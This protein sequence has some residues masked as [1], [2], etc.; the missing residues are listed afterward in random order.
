MQDISYVKNITIIGT[1]IQGHAIAQV[2]LMAGFSKVILNDLSIELINKAVDRIV[3]DP[4]TGL[5]VLEKEGQLEN[6]ITTEILVKRLVKEVNLQNAVENVDF[7]IEA[8]PEVMNIKKE[9]FRKLGQYCPEHT[10]F[11]TNTSTMSITEIGKASG[12]SEK[13]IGMHFF[14][15]LEN[16]LIEITKGEKT[17]EDTLKI[18]TEVGHK[19]PSLE[20]KRLLIE[21]QR[22]SPGFI[23]N[24]IVGTIEIYITWLIEQAIARNIPFE[25][26]DADV[27]DFMPMGIFCLCDYIGIDTVFNAMKYFEE[28]LSPDFA[29]HKLFTKL[30]NENNLGQ[31]TG[32][33]FYDWS[34]NKEPSIDRSKTAGLVDIELLIAIQLNEGCRMI[35]EGCVSNYKIIDKAVSTGYRSPGPFSMGKKNYKQLVVKLDEFAELTGRKYLKP[36]KLMRSGGFLDMKK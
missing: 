26:L 29:P 33:G 19:L 20:G 8:V 13:V 5:K 3:N 23:A 25:Q 9:V 11:A 27:I 30:I 17:S 7:V 15:P 28:T 1:G 14:A 22:E 18:A 16:K 4:R 6:K 35:E 31:K 2:A 34:Q 24:R 36:C 21:L 10:I 32:R 12:R